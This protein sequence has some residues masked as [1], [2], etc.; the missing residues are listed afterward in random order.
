MVHMLLGLRHWG[1]K[2]N[3]L[4]NVVVLNLQTM[5]MSCQEDDFMNVITG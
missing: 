4:S 1:G 3:A 5:M 2:A